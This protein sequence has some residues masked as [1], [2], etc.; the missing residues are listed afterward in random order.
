MKATKATPEP[1]QGSGWRLERRGQRRLLKPRERRKG[2]FRVSEGPAAALGT[3]IRDQTFIPGTLHPPPLVHCSLQRH[4][5]HCSWEPQ[6]LL[7][8]PWLIVRSLGGQAAFEFSAAVPTCG[9]LN[10]SLSC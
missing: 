10:V 1:E 5:R 8:L 9:A 6:F 7:H 4:L 2:P 3:A